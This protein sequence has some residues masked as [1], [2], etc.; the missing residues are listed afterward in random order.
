MKKI[1]IALLLALASLLCIAGC[2]TTERKIRIS[3]TVVGRQFD[4]AHD[5]Q[6]NRWFILI[7]DKGGE[8]WISVDEGTYSKL[9][10]GDRWTTNE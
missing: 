7:R 8:I 9:K 2:N 3:G 1:L 6:P 10:N 5:G 4:H